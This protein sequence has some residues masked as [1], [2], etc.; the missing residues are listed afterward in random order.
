MNNL[1]A[2]LILVIF[3]PNIHYVCSDLTTLLILLDQIG[4]YFRGR[5]GQLQA[6]QLIKGLT[7]SNA[8]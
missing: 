6:Y 4:G 1:R 8:I 2:A 7:L 3:M 5:I